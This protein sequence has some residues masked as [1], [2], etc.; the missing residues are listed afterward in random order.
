M[1]GTVVLG[2]VKILAHSRH[3]AP[4]DV[5]ASRGARWLLCSSLAC[6]LA[7]QVETIADDDLSLEVRRLIRQLDATKLAQREEAEQKLVQL[8]PKVLDLLPV[9]DPMSAEMKE[10]LGRIRQQLQ[11]AAAESAAKASLITLRGDDLPLWEVLA[12]LEKQS[13][14]KIVAGQRAAGVKLAVDFDKTPFWQALDRTLDGAE[15]TVDPHGEQRAIHLVPRDAARTARTGHACYAGP[16]RIEP[17]FIETRRDLRHTDSQSLR[18][19]LDVAWEPRLK[20]V[21]L[22]IPAA[23]VEAIDENGNPLKLDDDQARLEIPTEGRT[24]VELPVFLA[25]P[26][27]EVKQIAR[28]EGTLLAMVPGKVEIFRF[29]DLTT[30]RNVKKRIA[31]V[32]VTLDEVRRT[33]AVWEV[34]ARA[35]FDEAGG[36]LQSHYGWIFDNDAHL[37]GP[38]GKPIRCDSLETTWQ[39]EN[40]VRVA[41]RFV[42]DGPPEKRTFVYKTPGVIVPTQ[43]DY[44]IRGVKLP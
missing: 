11:R 7:G 19:T 26:P 30:A 21:S 44:E 18:L 12:A 36:T 17:I 22:E 42:L 29:G 10:R 40:E 5:A 9:N 41:Y 16:F 4:R 23:K 20:P 27:R 39:A 15:M 2:L 3:L 14:N 13:G 32:T 1:L 31:G 34:L 33:D 8:G 25:L 24:S 35:R 37:E 38:D 28:I 43:I 6:V